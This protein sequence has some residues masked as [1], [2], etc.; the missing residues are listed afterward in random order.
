MLVPPHCFRVHIFQITERQIRRGFFVSAKDVVDK[1]DAFVQ[2]YNAK[3]RPF[4][5]TATSEA[6]LEKTV[7]LCKAV[8]GAEQNRRGSRWTLD[9]L[10]LSLLQ[11][12]F[13]NDEDDELCGH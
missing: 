2:A 13:F 12:A 5:W 3:A 8:C 4:V 6:I 7:R 10:L 9:C 11:H 1:I